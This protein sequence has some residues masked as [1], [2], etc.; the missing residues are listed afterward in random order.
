MCAIE[1]M[2]KFYT[3]RTERQREGERGE[4][5]AERRGKWNKRERE[6]EG[7]RERSNHPLPNHC[8]VRK[9]AGSQSVVSVCQQGIFIRA[10]AKLGKAAQ[11]Y[12]FILGMRYLYLGVLKRVFGYGCALSVLVTTK[13][14]RWVR[15]TSVDREVLRVTVFCGR[16]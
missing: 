9:G 3:E 8:A 14:G 6:R 2:G 16:G 11:L 1:L 12:V 7:G 15:C 13:A 10:A 5:K 4:G